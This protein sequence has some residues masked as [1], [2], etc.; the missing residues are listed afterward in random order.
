MAAVVAAAR[1]RLASPETKE[2]AA[3][4][5]ISLVSHS[6]IA[7]AAGSQGVMVLMIDMLRAQPP[8]AL[9]VAALQCAC[10][11]M[12]GRGDMCRL[13]A[14]SGLQQALRAEH[15]AEYGADFDA[16]SRNAECALQLYS[17]MS[18]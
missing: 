7:D 10:L 14:D 16:L 18:A 11:L 1:M 5:L 12:Y 6:A 3:N 13:A 17:K 15:C 2:L 8:A 4:A 9:A